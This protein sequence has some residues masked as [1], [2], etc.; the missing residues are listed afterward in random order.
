MYHQPLQ[1]PHVA[2]QLLLQPH[3]PTSQSQPPAVGTMDTTARKERKKRICLTLQDKS[4]I[5]TELQQG[6]QMSGLAEKY[7]VSLMTIYSIRKHAAEIISAV[8]SSYVGPSDQ[9]KVMRSGEFAQMEERLYQWFCE[10]RQRDAPVSGELLKA[11]ALLYFEQYKCTDSVFYASEGW[12]QNFKNRFGIRL[13][14]GEPGNSGGIGAG[15]VNG[16]GSNGHA[17]IQSVKLSASPDSASGQMVMGNGNGQVDP[18]KVRMNEILRE[19][20][21]SNDQ[22]LTTGDD[23]GNNDWRCVFVLAVLV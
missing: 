22:L 7:G 12:L 18:L 17:A 4:K 5:I 19:L 21:L 10:Q 14:C 13:A 2:P 16:G 8:G 6:A 15:G 11:Q 3:T 20:N 23:A 1:S 9:K